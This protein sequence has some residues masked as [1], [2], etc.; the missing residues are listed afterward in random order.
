MV[1]ICRSKNSQILLL[2]QI[3]EGHYL[4]TLFTG[5]DL[6]TSEKPDDGKKSHPF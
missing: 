5:N 6:K 1:F 3:I 4:V 2:N